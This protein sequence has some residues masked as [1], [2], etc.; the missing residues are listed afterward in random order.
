MDKF[1]ERAS[2]DAFSGQID[3]VDLIKFEKLANS[4]LML[5]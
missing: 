5:A 1:N 3:V 4:N 2:D